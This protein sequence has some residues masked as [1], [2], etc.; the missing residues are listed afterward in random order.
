MKSCIKTIELYYEVNF[1]INTA[2]NSD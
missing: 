2:L 1:V